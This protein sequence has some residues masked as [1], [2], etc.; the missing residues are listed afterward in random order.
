[1]EID[2]PQPVKPKVR[3]IKK[4]IKKKPLSSSNNSSQSTIT[5]AGVARK[6]APSSSSTTEPI[7]QE[8][9]VMPPNQGLE[10][11]KE[12]FRKQLT[13][14]VKVEKK[15]FE[16]QSYLIDISVS[17]AEL[18]QY[19]IF[20][21]PNHY[22]DIVLERAI[23][24][25][26]GF[27]NCKNQ[28]KP[29]QNTHKY[30]ISTKDQKVYDQSE[31]SNYCSTDCLTKSK[32]YRFTLDPTPVHLRNIDPDTFSIK[33][34]DN[35]IENIEN[36]LKIVE[37]ESASKTP[38]NMK[39]GSINS[40]TPVNSKIV[41][42]KPL[43]P[44]ATP[45]A[46]AAAAVVVSTPP[47]PQITTTNIVV[48]DVDMKTTPK[49]TKRFGNGGSSGSLSSLPK[50]IISDD[51]HL[52]ADDKSFTDAM[53]DNMSFGGEDG[54]EDDDDGADDYLSTGDD[55]ESD[56]EQSIYCFYEKPITS[57]GKKPNQPIS[58]YHSVYSPL[59]EWRTIETER[60]FKSTNND[61]EPETTIPQT[62]QIKQ[63]L[64]HYLSLYYPA[65]LNDMNIQET[66]SKEHLIDLVDTFSLTRPIPS[67]SASHWKMVVLV[68][69]YSLT[70][71][72]ASLKQH[73]DAHQQRLQRLLK[74][75]GFDQYYLKVFVDL[76]IN[77]YQ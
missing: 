49:M 37:N 65:I 30:I 70:T 72:F 4:V 32:F 59:S 46:P 45:V 54:D 40:D 63:A 26:C 64:H 29:N 7:I 51:E 52:T 11:K 19:A 41:L 35:I 50:S 12:E 39:F 60:Y 28:I 43:V 17:D 77:G 3:V 16:I 56:S 69:I 75:F 34:E 6:N 20:L 61:H 38:L 74:D 67:L 55:Q 36:N 14:K 9:G 76:V 1:M 62:P 44:I 24:K 33:P 71:R 2:S 22:D 68:L 18:K 53:S 27:P 23:S 66:S 21:Q 48:E 25:L 5:T 57:V 13:E 47:P 42:N 73:F 8:D 10:R 31:L 15:T 58:N